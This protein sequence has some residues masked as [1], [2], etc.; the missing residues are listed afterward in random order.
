MR[1]LYY[2]IVLVLLCMTL[3]KAQTAESI[4][5]KYT[6][7]TGGQENWD[8]VQSMDITGTAKL[9]TQNME[10]PYHRVMLNDGRQITSLEFN[11]MTYVDTAYDGTKIWGSNSQMEAEVKDTEALE[12]MKRTMSDFPYPGH[13]WKERGYKATYMGTE[14][15]EGVDTYKVLLVRHTRLVN[16][17]EKDNE[18][19]IYFDAKSYFPIFTESTAFSGPSAGGTMRTFL[20]NYKEVDGLFYPFT[21]TMKNGDETFQIL[22]A[23]TVKWN[24][25]I[26]PSIFAMPTN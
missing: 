19:L 5:Q 2:C 16:G 20:S 18:L 17:E 15:I 4:L 1:T 14:Q 11:G 12:N 24:A 8:R 23:T 7:V 9:V 22:E 21:V 26:D 6:E 3:A 25:E 10:L 13:N